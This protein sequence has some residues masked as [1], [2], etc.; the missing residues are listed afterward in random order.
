MLFS[1]SLSPSSLARNT[2]LFTF[3]NKT[4]SLLSNPTIKHAHHLLLLSSPLKPFDEM[5]HLTK[6]PLFYHHFSTSTLSATLHESSSPTTIITPMSRKSRKKA[7]K[8]SPE[9]VLKHKLD[10][11]SK[12]EEVDEALRLYDEGR[13]CGTQ[14]NLHHYNV[15]L[16]LCSSNDGEGYL[17]RG[18][19]IFE[20]MGV[21]GVDPNEATFTSAARLAAKMEDPDMAFE[22]VKKM[23]CGFNIPP[24]LR[25]Y[26]P[27]LFG[28]CKKREPDKAYEVDVHMVESGVLA[29]EPELAE[30][31]RVSSE[32]ARG[33]K[34]YEMLHRLRSSVRQVSESTADIT[35]AWFKSDA[36]EGVG[37]NEIDGYDV[38]KKVREGV[39]NGGGG[40]HGQG[41]LEKGKWK[42]IRTEMDHQTGVCRCCGEKLVSID[43]DPLETENFATSL[44]SLAFQRERKADF[45]SF[46][47]WLQRHGPFDAVIDGANLGLI[48]QKM[49]NFFQLNSV[50]NSIQQMSPTKKL[51]LVILHNHRVR[52][53][54]AEK[55]N[56]KKLLESWEKAGALYATPAGSNDDWYWLYAAVTSKSL[57]VTNDEMRDHLFQLLG[58]SFF[59][60]WKEKH[61]VR[62]TISGKGPALH[63][64]PIYS[65]V[66]QESERGSWHVP[67]VVGDDIEVPRQWLCVTRP[68]PLTITTP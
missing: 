55:P 57:L 32:S 15:L 37:G 45:S 22:L 44:S 47:E 61:Q 64:P 48:R 42:V 39:V 43:I 6:S 54:P 38:V 35:E 51:P 13:T 28:F 52:G 19:E 58:T 49:F 36:A 23:K 33:E 27:A 3:F 30:L 67:T 40:W 5:P 2:S 62:V 18:F 63:M 26:G 59:P 56:N 20:R 46:Q 9:A 34:V 10:M 53:G 17:R 21:D 16:Y 12:H 25:S 29:E 65:I 41:W 8:E 4:P 68:S 66:I 60:R 50:V 11:C 31:L 14:L 7:Y 24:K 1:S